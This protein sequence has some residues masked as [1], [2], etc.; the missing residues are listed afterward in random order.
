MNNDKDLPSEVLSAIQQNQKIKAI[1]LLRKHRKIELKEAK[2][3]VDA[4]IK[5][6]PNVIIYK[7][8]QNTGFISLLIRFCLIVAVLYLIYTLIF[9]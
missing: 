7:D 2:Q 8:S 3:I 5:N 1:K 4:Y 9:R 6:N